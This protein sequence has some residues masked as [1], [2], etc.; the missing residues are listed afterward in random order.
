MMNPRRR[1]R[2]GGGFFI[3]KHR[4]KAYNE[5]GVLSAVLSAD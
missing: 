1:P 3:D 5:N 2:D 4:Q